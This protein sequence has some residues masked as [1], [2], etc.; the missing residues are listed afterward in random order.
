M[1]DGV[2]DTGSTGKGVPI[3]GASLVEDGDHNKPRTMHRNI[4]GV[5]CA[6]I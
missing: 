4:V 2:N 1:T 6:N 3:W 5:I